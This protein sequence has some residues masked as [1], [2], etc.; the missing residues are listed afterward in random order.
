M[1][2]DIETGIRGFI[3]ENFLFRSDGGELARDASL[4][5]AGLID[6]MGVLE[7][8]AF[9]EDRFGLKVADA[10]MTP[11]NLDSIAALTA[12]VAGRTAASVAA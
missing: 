6:S 12:F 10:D 8:V 2:D 3:E 5:E 7:L 1:I 11:E 4:L 9:L